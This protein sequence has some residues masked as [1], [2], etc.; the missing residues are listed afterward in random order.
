DPPPLR[1]L[2]KVHPETGRTCLTIGRHAY[3]IPGLSEEES[4]R[5]LDELI[6]FAVQPPRVYYHSWMPGDIVIWDNRCLLHQARPWDMRE[7][8]VMY[9][10][11]IASD[12]KREFA[13]SDALA[14]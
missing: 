1:P 6:E 5:L 10:S 7:P 9:H 14:S 3:G 4:E 11:R 2:V 8:R 13:P 12:P